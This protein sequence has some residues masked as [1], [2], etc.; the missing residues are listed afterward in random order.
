MLNAEGNTSK[1]MLN[2]IAPKLLLII[3]DSIMQFEDENGE[4]LTE[5]QLFG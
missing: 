4:H 5:N 2:Q 1:Q 3:R